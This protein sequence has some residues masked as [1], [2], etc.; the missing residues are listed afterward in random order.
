[1]YIYMYLYL[2]L[3]GSSSVFSLQC[4]LRG[5]CAQSKFHA[6]HTEHAQHFPL[7]YKFH[8]LCRDMLTQQVEVSGVGVVTISIVVTISMVYVLARN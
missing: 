6:Y 2:W 5:G 3:Y 1:M 4:G 7:A 8:R